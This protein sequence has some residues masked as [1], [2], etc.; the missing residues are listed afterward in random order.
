MQLNK[1]REYYYIFMSLSS[2]AA[3]SKA[4]FSDGFERVDFVGAKNY[5]VENL[6][7]SKYKVDINIAYLFRL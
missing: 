1:G 2:F 3:I 7:Y 6:L 4:I 5:I